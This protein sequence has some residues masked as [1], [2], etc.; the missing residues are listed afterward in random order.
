[1]DE[2]DYNASGSGYAANHS[3]RGH[4]RNDSGSLA[5][6]ANDYQKRDRDRFKSQKYARSSD[7]TTQD[8]LQ[9]DKEHKRIQQQQQEQ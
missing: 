9:R 7:M 8:Q 2:P 6:L 3:R 1:M 5:L 4:R